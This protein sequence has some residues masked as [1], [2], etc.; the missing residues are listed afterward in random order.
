MN[1][2]FHP[3]NGVDEDVL[4]LANAGGVGPLALLHLRWDDFPPLF[5][6]ESDMHSRVPFWNYLVPFWNSLQNKIRK[7]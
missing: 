6:A 5:C 4:V 1:M 2:V 3:A 7:Y